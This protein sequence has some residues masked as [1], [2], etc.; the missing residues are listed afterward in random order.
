MYELVN[1]SMPNGLIAGTHGFAT[2]AMTKGVSDVLRSRLE[3][4]CA[5]THRTSVHDST[6]YQENPVN[7]FHVILPQG[8]H[9]VGRVSPSDF[10]YTG[11]TNRLARLRVFG[12]NEMPIVGG[13]EILIRDRDW[14]SE[15]WKGEPRYLDEDKDICSNL[16]KLSPIKSS[17]APAWD[18]LFGHNGSTYAQQ[19]AWQLEKNLT[20]GGKTIYFKTSPAFDVKGE[21]LLGLFSEIINLLP[22]ELRSNITFSTY[23]VALPSG[24]VCNLRAIHECDKIFEASSSTQAWVD[25]ENARIVHAE[26]LPTSRFV[27]GADAKSEA[28]NLVKNSKA[29]NDSLKSPSCDKFN[30]TAS[31]NKG[32]SYRDFITPKKKKVDYFVVGIIAA[33]LAV[34]LVA[35]GIF[36]LMAQNNKQKMQ[37]SGVVAA[38]EESK[39]L[40]A[41]RRELERQEAIAKEKL[42]AERL[43][44]AK[45]EADARKKR[46]AE[47]KAKEEADAKAAELRK[48]NAE[49]EAKARADLA[50]AKAKRDME[51]KERE[52]VAYLDATEIKIGWPIHNNAT[53]GSAQDKDSFLSTEGCRVF[54]YQKG[55]F[56]NDVAGF[57]T[58]SQWSGGILCWGENLSSKDTDIPEA[59]YGFT[60][61]Y[62]P[63]H[64]R[65]YIDFRSRNIEKKEQWFSNTNNVVDLAQKCFGPDKHLRELWEK[66][67]ATESL[68]RICWELK[69]INSSFETAQVK[70]SYDKMIEEVR[71]IAIREYKQEVDKQESRKSRCSEELDTLDKQLNEMIAQTNKMRRVQQAYNKEKKKYGDLMDQRKELKDK[72]TE[73]ISMEIKKSKKR[74]EEI[75]AQGVEEPDMKSASEEKVYSNSDDLK[76]KIRCVSS[77]I[78]DIE[79]KIGRK[80]EEIKKANKEIESAESS[81]EYIRN[82]RDDYHL[83]NYSVELIDNKGGK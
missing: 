69:N 61:W 62:N 70:W 26:L 63:Y 45:K 4:L 24:V 7:L 64:K 46:D 40:E 11:R 35:G 60:L 27:S 52:K 77:K 23:P 72:P 34:L 67:Q 32:N 22:I 74:M 47:V 75:L 80:K 25:C 55:I 39:R 5:Y 2:V 73:T 44:L 56:T 54:F 1:T 15:S 30:H 19:I 48:R 13:A 71:N 33:S 10:D 83:I 41:E 81:I 21:K 3:S 29:H 28:S 9:V 8:E 17:S 20:V 59:E 49:K 79:Q 43:K 82:E 58:V 57:R 68:Y 76:F 50:S 42:E 78:K 36:F 16:Q 53:V 37:D 6:Y 14:F 38:I 12:T 51:A 65:V 31:I 18:A 66:Y